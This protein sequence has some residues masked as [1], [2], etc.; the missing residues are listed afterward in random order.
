M[1]SNKRQ[2]FFG[3]KEFENFE[4]FDF[5]LKLYYGTHKPIRNRK[6]LKKN[7]Y[8]FFKNTFTIRTSMR[9][10]EL[11]KKLCTSKLQLLNKHTT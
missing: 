4:R 7:Y 3:N 6:K 8:Q 1:R 5:N 9:N 11:K 2:K 10:A